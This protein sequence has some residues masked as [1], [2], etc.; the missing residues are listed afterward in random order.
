M[1]GSWW[2]NEVLSGWPVG[3]M[4]EISS[5]LSVAGVIAVEDGPERSADGYAEPPESGVPNAVAAD[6][7][8]RA[9]L[10]PVCCCCTV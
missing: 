8:S 4:L 2:C 10:A 3:E 7:S 1:S 5:R 9:R 6:G